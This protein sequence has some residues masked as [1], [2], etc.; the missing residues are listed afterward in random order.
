[1]ILRFLLI[2]EMLLSEF[3]ATVNDIEH[4]RESYKA[5]FEKEK[6]R[7]VGLLEKETL[8][9]QEW[10]KK[11]NDL[12]IKEEI[13]TKEIEDY[14]SISKNEISAQL[15]LKKKEFGEVATK[16]KALREK[17]M[18]LDPEKLQEGDEVSYIDKLKQMVE[19]KVKEGKKLQEIL[20]ELKD[21]NNVLKEETKVDFLGTS[22]SMLEKRIEELEEEGRKGTH[23]LKWAIVIGDLFK[24]QMAK[25]I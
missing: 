19:K 2:L 25:A 1:M 24:E 3:D 14:N 18:E 23:D 16:V 7:L 17:V 5:E 9:I 12:R 13:M 20:D 21:T 4:N 10:E 15:T 11:Y 22:I 6:A 8:I